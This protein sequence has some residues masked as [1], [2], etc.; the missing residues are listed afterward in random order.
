MFDFNAVN[1]TKEVI[2]LLKTKKAT[3]CF[4]AIENLSDLF[5]SRSQMTIESKKLH[6]A[7][8][9]AHVKRNPMKA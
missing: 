7:K 1:F 9:V 4:E 8:A 5:R 2:I 3:N 6:F